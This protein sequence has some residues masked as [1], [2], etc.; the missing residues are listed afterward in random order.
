MG[1]LMPLKKTRVKLPANTPKPK[2]RK[3]IE[4]PVKAIKAPYEPLTRRKK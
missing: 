1:V 3:R 4:P 2:P